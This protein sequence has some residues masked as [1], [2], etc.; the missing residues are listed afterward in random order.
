MSASGIIS[1]KN[2]GGR[3]AVWF[4]VEPL[5][6]PTTPVYADRDDLSIKEAA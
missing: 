3:D 4:S 6:E 1:I 5:Q 2:V